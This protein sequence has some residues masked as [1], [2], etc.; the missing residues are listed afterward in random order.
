LGFLTWKN[1]GK[2]RLEKRGEKGEGKK[3]QDRWVTGVRTREVTSC[4]KESTSGPQ[5]YITYIRQ[6]R[7]R[8]EKKTGKH[9]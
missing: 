3:G 5:R 9:F 7:E 2:H 1:W 4:K 6:L 8:R